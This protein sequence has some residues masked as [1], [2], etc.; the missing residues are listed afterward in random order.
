MSK[1]RVTVATKN[2]DRI[3]PLIDG[4][5]RAEGIDLNFVVLPVEETFYRQAR[6]HEFD[7]S[8]MSLSTYVLMCQRDDPE[9]IAIPVFPSRYFRHQTMFVHSDSGVTSPE[10]LIGKRI[11]VP[12]YQIT[13]TVW[14]RGILQDDFGVR[15]SDISWYQGGVEKAGR[16]EKLRLDLPETVHVENIPA[17]RTLNEML[18]AREIEG[19]FTAHVPSVVSTDPAIRRLFPDYKATELDYFNRTRI[20][21]I[22]HVVVI[23]R[24]LLAEHR[25]LAASLFKAFEEARKV[26]LDDLHYRSALPIMLPWLSDHVDETE[27]AMGTSYWSYGLEENHH[28]LDTFL[29]YSF[30]QGLAKHRMA[31]EE[32]FTDTTSSAFVI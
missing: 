32:V 23:R 27:A 8:E 10:Q 1:V 20:F 19:L 3:N 16:I 30:Q 17:D 12:E 26:A 21:P 18:V 22:M 14:Q 4:R 31:P 5:V 2:Y 25:W 11:G 7:V 29:R 24:S 15:P 28:V 9:Y 6:F 13:A